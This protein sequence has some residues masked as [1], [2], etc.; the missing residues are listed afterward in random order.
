MATCE[1]RVRRRGPLK[2]GLNMSAC[3][4]DLTRSSSTSVSQSEKP[5]VEEEV[6]AAAAGTA[7]VWD[8]VSP[9]HMAHLNPA[10]CRLRA[11]PSRGPT[12]ALKIAPTLSKFRKGRSS[13]W[14]FQVMPFLLVWRKQPPQ[15]KLKHTKLQRCLHVPSL[16]EQEGFWC[17]N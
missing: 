13:K 7:T 15:H 11:G 10:N 5:Q 4:A 12:D 16:E 9:A 6:D 3:L 1:R 2:T 14:H 17:T 8:T